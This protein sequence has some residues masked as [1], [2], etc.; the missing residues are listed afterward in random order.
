V[1][2]FIA[3]I[4][5]FEVGWSACVLGA[6]HDLAWLGPAVV[7]VI[8]V[9]TLATDTKPLRELLAVICVAAG[10]LALD[11]VLLV[12]GL[13]DMPRSLRIGGA[14][15]AFFPVFF[16]MWVNFALLL[17][18]SLFWLRGRWLL[19]AFLGAVAAAPTYLLAHR[20]GAVALAEPLWLTL[21]VVAAQYA[22]AVPA[23][24]WLA[25]RIREGESLGSQQ[26]E[27][28]GRAA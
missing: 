3:N 11:T 2:R 23:A 22:V 9:A 20:L 5:A 18:V 6:A 13:L 14:P 24:S 4:I 7:A 10:G 27:L 8:A 28:E 19:A 25:W 15:I 26:H 21:A 12:T 1:I 16:A 17:N